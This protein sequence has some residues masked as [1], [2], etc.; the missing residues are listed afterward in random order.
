MRYIS[1]SI[2]NFR[3]PMIRSCISLL[4]LALIPTLMPAQKTASITPDRPKIGDKVTLTYFPA[5]K[6]ARF[7]DPD[8]MNAH[9]LLMRSQDRPV[10]HELPMSRAGKNWTVSLPLEDAKARVLL[11]QFVS[12]DTADDNAE[13]VWMS[14]VYGKNNKPLR[15]AHLLRAT[16][17]R[18]GDYYDFK[19]PRD[20]DAAKK[21]LAAEKQAY[22]DNPQAH[23]MLW[24]LMIRENPGEDTKKLIAA[25]LDKLYAKYQASEE[26]VSGILSWFSQTDQKDR[27][28]EITT[29]WTEKNPKG[30]IAQNAR[31]SAVYAERDGLKRIPL[32]ETYLADFPEDAT[33]KDNAPSMKLTAYM[34]AKDYD[35]AVEVIMTMHPL[36]GNMFNT[37]A[38]SCIEKDIELDRAVDWA[39][40]GIDILRHPDPS[41]KPAYMSAKSWR[42]QNDFSLGMILDTYATGLSKQGRIQEALNAFQEAYMKCN[43]KQTDINERYLESCVVNEQY[44]LAM[45]VATECL[46]KGTA[47]DTM[48]VPFKTA[49]VKLRGSDQGFDETVANARASARADLRASLLKERMNKPSID[50]TLK[51]LDGGTVKL[52][53]LKGKVV[54]IDFWATWCGPCKASFPSLQK[55]YDQYKDNDKVMILTLDT[56][57]NVKGEEKEALVQKFIAD[58]KYTFPVLYDE[59]YVEKYGVTGIPTKFIIDKEGKIQFKSIGF[60]SGQKLIDELTI[61]IELL[62]DDAFYAEKK[63]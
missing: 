35:K 15:D 63:S 60:E 38:W 9:V 5:S 6:T 42:D 1:N 62:L 26:I 25:E 51:G 19:Y 21:A 7:H 11:V 59:G 50:F 49:Y 44:E 47:S 61:Q 2:N 54:V 16:L 40:R 33:M 37:L 31:R 24:S 56:W 30:I 45:Q 12:H 39:M 43:A 20:V 22:P 8:E 18:S 53:A 36:N 55:V 28:T 41:W 14:M 17:L 10:L 57:E 23:S 29:R 27:A 46:R 3:C 4:L 13:H 48:L 58:N 34:Q 52:S 32:L